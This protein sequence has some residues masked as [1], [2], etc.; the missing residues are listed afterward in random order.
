MCFIFQGSVAKKPYNPIIGETF[1][2][3]WKIPPDP[4]GGQGDNDRKPYLM[5]YCAEQVSHHPPGK[6]AVNII[7]FSIRVCNEKLNFLILMS[8]ETHNLQK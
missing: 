2:C 1:H 4:S 6:M 8:N 7:I 3:S 5:T